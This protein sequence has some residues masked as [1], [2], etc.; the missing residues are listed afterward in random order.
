MR[1]AEKGISR[2]EDCT[3]SCKRCVLQLQRTCIAFALQNTEASF[4]ARQK[5]PKL[6]SSINPHERDAVLEML[7]QA[8]SAL[9]VTHLCQSLL[10]HAL[11]CWG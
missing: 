3:Y 10:R 4:A 5:L 6:H 9:A 7:K 1:W 8:G 2:T 11:A